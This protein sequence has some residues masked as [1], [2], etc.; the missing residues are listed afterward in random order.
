VP[1][2]GNAVVEKVATPLILTADWPTTAPSIEKTTTP[3]GT[4]VPS[5]VTVAV[6][7]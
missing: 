5:D 4:V 7:E 1:A 2:S 6:K 3:V